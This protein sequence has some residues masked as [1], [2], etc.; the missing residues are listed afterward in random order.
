M[1]DGLDFV[2]ILVDALRPS[3]MQLYGYGLPTTPNLN[4][5]ADNGVIFEN[6]YCTA[7]N[8]D[9][10]LTALFT[11][12]YP[13]VTGIHN[14]GARTTVSEIRRAERLRYITEIL[15]DHGFWT[16]AVDVSDRWHRKGFCEYVYQ[17]KSNIYG[18]GSI[19]NEILDRIHA[20]D[21]FFMVI[22]QLVPPRHL[23]PANLRAEDVTDNAIR[24]IRKWRNR[25]NFLFVHYW[26]THTPYMPPETLL[27]RFLIDRELAGLKAKTPSD[28]VR[29]FK[30]PLL[31][32]IDCAWLRKLPSIKYAIAA[33]DGAVAHV[34][35]EIGRI[36]REL[37]DAGRSD[38][39]VVIVTADHGESLLEHEV[40]FDHHSLFEPVVRVPL[41]ILPPEGL[42]TGRRRVTANVTH[43]DLFPTILDLAEIPFTNGGLSGRSLLPIMSGE[44]VGSDRPILIEESHFE[45]KRAVRLGRYKMIEAMGGQ[46]MECRFCGRAHGDRTELFDLLADPNETNNLVKERPDLV[47][48]FEEL[49]MP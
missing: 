14:H 37:E 44:E 27:R 21:F 25:K 26:D 42:S 2:V 12:Q 41:V 7:T 36:L 48:K 40:F 35:Q 43:V 46:P 39:T 20:Y 13:S 18:L 4:A 10:S 31:K 38:G 24:L 22:S 28:I 23:P 6:A 45:R 47:G 5:H 19:G 32:P 8:T 15:R 1:G 16:G 9:P 29:S 30:R 3:N 49:A 11:G 34:D 33:Y 17:T